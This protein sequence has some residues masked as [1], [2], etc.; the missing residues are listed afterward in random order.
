M[1]LAASGSRLAAGLI[2]RCRSGRS[3]VLLSL[4]LRAHAPTS[5]ETLTPREAAAARS[6][7]ISSGARE[8]DTIRVL[9]LA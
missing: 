7:A 5:A 2:R 9:P 6:R 1:V 8:S 4:S 3:S